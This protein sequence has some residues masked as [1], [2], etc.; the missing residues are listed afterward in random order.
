MSIELTA[1]NGVS[2]LN[3]PEL[4]VNN[5]DVVPLDQQN[6]QRID[7]GIPYQVI[8]LKYAVFANAVGEMVVPVM[9]YT[10]SKGGQRSL[11][12]SGGEQ[13]VARNKQLVISVQEA[14]KQ[15]SD[16]WFPAE[17][18]ALSSKWS[19]DPTQLKV[20][21]PITRTVTVTAV[22]QRSRA[23]PPLGGVAESEQYNSYKDQPQTNDKQSERGFIGTRVESEAIVASNDGQLMIPEVRLAW[24]DVG[25]K[26]WKEAVLP[27]ETITAV[28]QPAQIAAANS[29]P[30]TNG[31]NSV[32]G[33]QPIT[34]RNWQLATAVLAVL[35]LVQLLIIT[36]LVTGKKPKNTAAGKAHSESEA[37]KLLLRS[38][39]N[40]DKTEI[41]N[42]LIYWATTAQQ[43]PKPLT[44]N[45]IKHQA[46]HTALSNEINSLET[47]LFE[48]GAEDT[49]NH[50]DTRPL[51]AALDAVRNN[52]NQ[53]KLA[54]E[55]RIDELPPLYK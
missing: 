34:L 17:N 33:A 18:V 14:P 45:A 20:G 12:G 29:G 44:L 10:A 47:A 25:A 54:T 52:F 21:E 6:F 1:Q 9:T 2:N 36:K 24:F 43:S 3:G 15:K 32:S 37:W 26:R 49:E 40:S 53:A 4:I 55:K 48:K 19:R 27:A 5:A 16:A 35:A 28:G 38:L 22:A 41:R 23:I 8:V 30:V 31:Q 50:F 51:R 11:F 46:N 39:K 7:N 42:H 13:V